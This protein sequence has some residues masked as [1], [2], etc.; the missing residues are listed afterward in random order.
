MAEKNPKKQ[1]EK[2]TPE[3]LKKLK[4]NPKPEKKPPFPFP[5]EEEEDSS[6]GSQ[7]EEKT[8]ET[9]AE[10]G[11]QALEEICGNF[12]VVLYQLWGIAQKGIEPLTENTKNLAS[13]PM[14][15]LAVKHNLDDKINDEIM[16][17]GI[18]GVD[19]TKRIIEL[20]KKKKADNRIKQKEEKGKI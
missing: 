16:L 6:T 7:T 18:L 12:L 13:P 4:K 14:A 5:I 20:N 9:E 17:A 1:A 19:V 15:R 11:W 8:E 2:P 3:Q 10:E